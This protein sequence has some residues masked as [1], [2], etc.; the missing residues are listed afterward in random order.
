MRNLD[1]LGVRDLNGNPGSA[2][3]INCVT[4]AMSHGHIK[5]WPPYLKNK[6]VG[7]IPAIY[8]IT[9]MGSTEKPGAKGLYQLHKETESVIAMHLLLRYYYSSVMTINTG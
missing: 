8:T 7:V 3:H 6:N 9:I 4:L 1:G 5:M 2:M